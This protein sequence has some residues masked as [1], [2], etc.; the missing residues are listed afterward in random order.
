MAC[1]VVESMAM[2][3]DWSPQT[4]PNEE[5]SSAHRRAG[6]AAACEANQAASPPH[7]TDD[8]ESRP[9]AEADGLTLLVKQLHDLGELGSCYV[10][11][12]ADSA[13]LV[14][15]STLVRMSWAALGFMVVAALIIT[16][17]WLLFSGIAEGLGGL[18]GGRLWIGNTVTGLGLSIVLGL[19]LYYRRA[20]RV[21][22][23][24]A[25]GKQEQ[26]QA[27]QPE[28]LGPRGPEPAATPA[29]PDE[30]G[31][32]ADQASNARLALAQA[33]Q[34]M[35]RTL[36]LVDD[37]RSCTKRH[38]WLVTGSAVVAGFVAGVVL[39]PSARAGID[40]RESKPEPPLHSEVEKRESP[41]AE[42]SD[43][44]SIARTTLASILQSVVHSAMAAVVATP[45]AHRNAGT[46]GAPACSD[47]SSDT[48][49]CR[50]GDL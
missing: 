48:G 13:K 28:Q 30:G 22:R 42:A 35:D 17:A 50:Q 5:H 49:P 21:A 8:L 34:D 23:A 32:L 1:T 6:R 14:L 37:V 46:A 24:S 40:H 20:A 7:A 2:S 29:P 16:A 3:V 12:Q 43:L 10:A 45:E 38:P 4:P 33:F 31:N 44:F 26:R 25:V 9:V 15:R 36:R 11:A 39:T 27:R 18:F 19:A 47:S 41:R